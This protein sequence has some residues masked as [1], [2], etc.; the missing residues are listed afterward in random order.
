MVINF[1]ITKDQYT[2]KD[3]LVLPDDHTFTDEELEAMKQVRFDNWY[4]IVTTPSD[5]S[6]PETPV[7]E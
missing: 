6:N 5:D 4:K 3:A 1:E 7:Q 2:L